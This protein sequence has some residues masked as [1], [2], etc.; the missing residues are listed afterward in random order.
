MHFAHHPASGIDEPSSI[1]EIARRTDLP[2]NT[3]CKESRSGAIGPAAAFRIGSARLIL[4][5]PSCRLGRRRGLRRRAAGQC[6]S[7]DDGQ[8]L[9]LCARVLQ[10]GCRLGEG[11][12]REE[13]TGF[14][15][16]ALATDAGG[17]RSGGAKHLAGPAVPGSVARY[18]AGRVTRLCGGCLGRR[19]G[20][21]DCAA[22][23]ATS[24]R[25][26]AWVRAG[27]RGLASPA[28]W[29]D[30]VGGKEGLRSTR[31]SLAR[32]GGEIAAPFNSRL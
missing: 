2:R 18:P 16:S 20:S 31:V 28:V 3:L 32:N 11:A 7:P 4:S 1:R 19:T 30:R 14:S 15:P 13:G 26:A 12:S 21:L 29:R 5:P 23:R 10:F 27:Q 8:P 17:P 9:C 25:V 6:P 24:E 22:S